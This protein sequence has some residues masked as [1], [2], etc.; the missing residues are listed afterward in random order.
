MNAKVKK[1]S[2][3]KKAEP[4]FMV[5]AATKHGGLDYLHISLIILVMILVALTFT[6]SF[7]KAPVV[8]PI[9]NNSSCNANCIANVSINNATVIAKAET[10]LAGYAMVNTSLS[11]LPY[12]MVTNSIRAIPLANRDWLITVNFINPLANDSVFNMS[13]ILSKN[14]SLKTIKPVIQSSTK[15]NAYGTVE[16][17][18]KYNCNYTLPI[19][20]YLITDPY[21]PAALSSILNAIN[22]SSTEPSKISVSYYF[23]FAKYSMQLY[24][25]YGVYS[26]QLLGNYL[27]SKQRGFKTF[28]EDLSKVFTGTPV[29]QAM[30]NQLVAE[31][32]IN[33]SSFS[34]CINNASSILNGQAALASFYNVTSTPIFIVNC[35]YLSLPQTVTSAID[36]AIN[37]INK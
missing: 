24:D 4:V 33:M 2:A 34:D 13:L 25:K 20:V 26:T 32:N 14:L 12:Y 8:V 31:A 1:S 11:L 18:N 29:S 6:L 37:Q 17:N 5:K 7:F 23:V 10:I 27:A 22:L 19:S 21:A 36:Y 16:I 15:I 35:H 30:L 28:V 9:L 3:G